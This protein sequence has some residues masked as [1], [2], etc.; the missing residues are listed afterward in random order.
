M[1]RTIACLVSYAQIV[2]SHGIAPAE[3]VCVATSQARDAKNGAVFFRR[4]KQETG[5]DFRVLSG[6]E[7]ARCSFTGGLVPGVDPSRAAIIDIGGGSTELMSCAG[8]VSVD[9]GS[10]RFTERYLNVPCDRCVSDEQFWECQAAVDAGLAPL[11]EWRKNLETGLQLVA[12]AGTATTLAAWHLRLPRY[13]AARID[14][15]VLTRG[16]VHR[17]TEELKMLPAE[18]RLELPGMQRGREDVLLAGALILWRAME[19]LDFSTCLVSSRGLRFG[20]L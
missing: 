8:G 3:T 9:V 10:V 16:D 5:F 20:V 14:E 2:K 19:L 15:A 13:D 18:K 6:D 12:V 7:E 4:V 1:E 17:M 11:V